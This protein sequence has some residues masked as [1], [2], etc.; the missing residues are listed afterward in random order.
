MAVQI[1]AI[2]TQY[3]YNKCDRGHFLLEEICIYLTLP[4]RTICDTK[5]ISKRGKIGLKSN[6]T[7]EHNIVTTNAPPPE[8]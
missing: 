3:M 2:L 1:N 6:L 8:E 5:S 4:L 7:K